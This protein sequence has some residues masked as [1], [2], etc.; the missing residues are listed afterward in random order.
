VPFP[1]PDEGLASTGA[2]FQF[3]FRC[4]QPGTIDLVLIPRPGDP[5]L[6]THFLDENF[7][8][9]DPALSSARIAC[10]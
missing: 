1:I 10:T 4:L 2:A 8:P 9:I 7:Q 5:Q 3:R 6:G